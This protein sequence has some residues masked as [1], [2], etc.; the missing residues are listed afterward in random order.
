MLV[1]LLCSTLCDH[2]GCSPPSSS[3]HGILQARIL[4]WVA[5]PFSRGSSDLRMEPR[6]LALQ[7]DFF[8][9]VEPPGKPMQC[10]RLQSLGWEDLLE[11]G[12]DV[13][14]MIG[15]GQSVAGYE[16]K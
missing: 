15:F 8:F 2:L 7:A 12:T 10:K 14:I 11:K 9:T 1:A 16:M 3:V 13:Q 4:E 6:S 5:S